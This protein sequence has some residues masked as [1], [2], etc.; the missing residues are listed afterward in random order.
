[1]STSRGA[2]W[3]GGAS[4]AK[5][6]ASATARCVQGPR[7]PVVGDRGARE[8]GD[9]QARRGATLAGS[10]RRKVIPNQLVARAGFGLGSLKTMV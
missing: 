9:Q 4:R 6:D 1:M 2:F 7:G 3:T 5:T 10:S 8:A